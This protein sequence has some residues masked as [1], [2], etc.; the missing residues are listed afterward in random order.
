MSIKKQNKNDALYIP[1]DEIKKLNDEFL[2]ELE[3]VKRRLS[4]I[5]DPAIITEVH[6]VLLKAYKAAI[7][8]KARESEVDYEIK[9]A[10][11]EARASELKPVRHNWAW[12]F[13]FRPLTNRAQ[14]IIEERA[15]LDADIIHGE[16]EKAIDDDYKKHFPDTDEK[17]FKRELMRKMREKLKETI[18]KADATDTNEAFYNE[19]AE[20]PAA[21]SDVP[22]EQ[23]NASK[24]ATQQL[25][26][27]MTFDD[28]Q[29]QQQAQQ[30][31]PPFTSG[32]RPRPPR[33]CRKQ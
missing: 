8:I 4:V 32:R 23:E 22:R 21:P 11:I 29:A 31:P 15:A 25:P 6:D 24:P 19:P 27:Q 13:L 26:G 14:D 10:A 33:S 9:R 18:E 16:A 17:L 30:S 7:D 3:S 20:P 12:R 1:L 5:K 28:V 2:T